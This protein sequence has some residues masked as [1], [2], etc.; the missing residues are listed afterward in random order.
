MSIEK[1]VREKRW[2]K[3]RYIRIAQDYRRIPFEISWAELGDF[4][5]KGWGLFLL[6]SV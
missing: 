5:G 2:G 6:S 3:E 1:D 4:P